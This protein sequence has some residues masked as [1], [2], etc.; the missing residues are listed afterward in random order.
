MGDERAETYLRRLAE[1]ELRRVGDE[2]RRFDAAA[3]NRGARPDTTLFR[4]TENAEGKVIR[5]GR[6]LVAAGVL[7]PDCLDRVT[8]DLHAALKVRS[9]LLL[10][11]D[12]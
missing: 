12:R 4:T 9:R 11:W 2:L 7:Q 3:G 5:A 8:S 6:I 10:D 1:T